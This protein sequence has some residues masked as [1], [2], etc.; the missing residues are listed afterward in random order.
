M[1]GASLLGLSGWAGC[2]SWD[3]VG[4]RGSRVAGRGSPQGVLESRVAGRK[5]GRGTGHGSRGGRLRVA[6]RRGRVGPT[7]ENNSENNDENNKNFEQ[8]VPISRSRPSL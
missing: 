6:G 3:S 7:N 8:Y 4:G 1:G 2:C 5:G